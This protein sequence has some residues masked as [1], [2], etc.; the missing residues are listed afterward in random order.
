MK[1]ALHSM[2]MTGA[3]RV[4]AIFAALACVGAGGGGIETVV[5]G[6]A[7]QALFAVAFAGEQGLAVG[8]AGQVL[9]TS[10]GGRTW[11]K[12]LKPVTTRALLGVAMAGD[13]AIAVGQS[14][15]V[16][17]RG[18]DGQWSLVAS[19][20]EERLLAVDVDPQGVAVAVGGFGKILLSRDGGSSW[21]SI[22]PSW[23]DGGYTDQGLE[24]H[25][26]AVDLAADGSITC[27]GEF[28]LILRSVDAGQS[29]AVLARGTDSLFSLELRDDGMGYAVGQGGTILRTTD[30]G[31]TW[32][33]VA[34]TSESNLL[35]VAS[36]ADGRVVVTAMR[37]MLVSDDGLAWR[38]VSGG[39]FA[40]AWY[41]GVATRGSG[42]SAAALVVGH[43]GRIV[44]IDL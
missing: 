25:L 42:A 28:G 18:V 6:T 44:R 29:W 13:R 37:D 24:P 31:A 8:A 26:Y 27:A 7:H 36:S 35:G 40:L 33:E 17:V 38:R 19:G 22:A 15:T 23:M 21:T 11:Q 10:D 39:D 1:A 4:A 14:G 30:R 20:T 43:S 41:T 32:S 16:L 34:S 3:R 5:S 12:Q 2:G 9:A